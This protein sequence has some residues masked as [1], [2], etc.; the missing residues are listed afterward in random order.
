MLDENS[1]KIERGG[2]LPT[3]STTTRLDLSELLV[4][5]RLIYC[6]LLLLLGPVL[7][8]GMGCP[9]RSH[10]AR[11][12]DYENMSDEGDLGSDSEIETV[13]TDLVAAVPPVTRRTAASQSRTLYGWWVYALPIVPIAILLGVWAMRLK[14]RKLDEQDAV[15]DTSKSETTQAS[16]D[17]EQEA[18]MVTE[19]A[20]DLAEDDELDSDAILLEPISS[21]SATS[22]S[23]GDEQFELSGPDLDF[24]EDEIQLDRDPALAEAGAPA[25]SK[26]PRDANVEAEGDD[27]QLARVEA[28]NNR[29]Q[30]KL[31]FVLQRNEDLK[32]KLRVKLSLISK[33]EQKLDF[34]IDRN[35]KLKDKLREKL[36]IIER[37]EGNVDSGGEDSPDA[38]GVDEK[39]ADPTLPSVNLPVQTIDE[40]VQTSQDI[41]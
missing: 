25:V 30:E 22:D 38:D 13:E 5:P 17:V 20:E 12:P 37:L 34:V 15:E 32:D 4:N 10:M 3:T 29:L 14:S 23:A 33:L 28:E 7:L 1:V 18:L 41:A 40:D 2:Q 9:D 27:P 21:V 24:D 6:L 36:Q 8:S 11:L 19:L 39:E 26:L 35:E 31:D 16:A